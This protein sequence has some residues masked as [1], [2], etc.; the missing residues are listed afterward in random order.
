MRKILKVIVGISFAA[1]F[2]VSHADIATMNKYY[3]KASLAPKIKSCQGNQQCNVFYALSKQWKSIPNGFHTPGCPDCKVKEQAKDGD[4][5]GLN[6]GY[7]LKRD[8]SN[9]LREAGEAVF[10]N[11]GSASKANERIFAEGLAVLIYLDHKKK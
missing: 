1:V 2:S 5:Y 10:Y 9:E 3:N 8:Y 11:G 6:K 4:G 7:S